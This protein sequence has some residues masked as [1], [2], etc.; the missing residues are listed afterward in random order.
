MSDRLGKWLLIAFL[1]AD[2]LML[3]AMWRRGWL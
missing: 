1:L 2:V 3:L